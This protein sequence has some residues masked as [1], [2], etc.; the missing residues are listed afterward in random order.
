MPPSVFSI[1]KGHPEYAIG[2]EEINM[3][4]STLRAIERAGADA[5]SDTRHSDLA[6][7]AAR[8]LFA[9]AIHQGHGVTQV[10]RDEARKALVD[11]ALPRVAD[12]LLGP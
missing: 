3:Q 10:Q 12:D 9:Y 2:G 6:V 1:T 11:S 8:V 5:V 4:G 7:I